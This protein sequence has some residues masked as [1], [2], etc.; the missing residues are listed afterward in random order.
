VTIHVAC[1]FI[2]GGRL[3]VFVRLIFV[4]IIVNVVRSTVNVLV[5]RFIISISVV[6]VVTR[7][8]FDVFVRPIIIIIA[9]ISVMSRGSSFNVF[10]RALLITVVNV[11][12]VIIRV[13]IVVI[14]P[15]A[16]QAII[17]CKATTE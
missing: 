12:N 5:R 13:T 10:I 7:D 9:V 2:V 11:V 1:Y 3:H 8:T 15:R 17:G 6:N 14:L 4:V 16:G